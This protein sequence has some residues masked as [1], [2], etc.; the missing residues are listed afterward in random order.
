VQRHF[1]RL[2]IDH[3]VR[4]FPAADTPLNHHIG[5][6]LSHR[7]IIA[8]AKRQRLKTVLVFE[9]DVRFSPDAAEALDPSMRDLEGHAWQL[10]Y[11]GGCLH[12]QQAQ[13]AGMPAP[14]DSFPDHAHSRHRVPSLCL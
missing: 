9:D 2:G 11:M 10:L 13:S 7:R 8:E 3:R 6:A 5:C 14:E 1:R 12:R 4:R